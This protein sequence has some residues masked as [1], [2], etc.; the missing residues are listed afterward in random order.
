[1]VEERLQQELDAIRDDVARLG[2]D[3][4]ELTRVVRTLAGEHVDDVKGSVNEG[5]D[6]ASEE[7]RRR[8]EDVREQGRQATEEVG[9]M[10]G[11]HP[12]G[13]LLGAFGIG[14]IMAQLLNAGGRR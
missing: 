2:E 11:Q 7:L 3:M 4:R 10:M 12:L 13:S 1:M 14:V 9:K 8:V 6:A 5:I